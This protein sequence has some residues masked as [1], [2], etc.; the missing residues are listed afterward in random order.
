MI[1]K[2]ER[3]KK[4]ERRNWREGK[5]MSTERKTKKSERKPDDEK[6]FLSLSRLDVIDTRHSARLKYTNI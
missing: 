4:S 2:K 1:K 6:V 3:K 5:R